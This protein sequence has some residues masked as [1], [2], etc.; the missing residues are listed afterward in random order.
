[1]GELVE[2]PR[3]DDDFD[4]FWR[5]YRAAIKPKTTRILGVDVVVPTDLPLSFEDQLAELE[6]SRTSEAYEGL[7]AT[8]FGEGTLGQWKANGITREQ[9]QIVMAWG[10]SNGSG[11]PTTFAEAA[12]KVADAEAEKAAAGSGGKARVTPNRATRRAS[13]RTAASG[14]TGRSSKRTSRANTG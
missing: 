1:M 12:K 6:G 4:A 9:L 10:F 5:D 7:L 3:E 11:T 2:L 8:L 14:G 13:S